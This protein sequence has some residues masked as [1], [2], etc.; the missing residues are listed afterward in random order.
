[1][2]LLSALLGALSVVAII[3]VP[4]PN[5]DQL[6]QLVVS[7]NRQY[8]SLAVRKLQDLHPSSSYDQ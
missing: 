6:S 4:Q 3:A 1:M 5:G 8:N 7:Y 2:Q